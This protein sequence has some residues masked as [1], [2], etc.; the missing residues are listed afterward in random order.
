LSG[1]VSNANLSYQGVYVFGGTN[2]LQVPFTSDGGN[3]P[4]YTYHGN[5]E[6]NSVEIGEGLSVQTNVPG[7]QLFQK[8]NASVLG[9]L[10]QLATALETGTGTDVGNATN[11]VSQALSYLSQQRVFYGNSM[12]QLNSQESFLQT[13]SVN[14]KSQEN[15]LVGADLAQVTTM[16][17]QA[18]TAHDA[19]LAAAAR[20]LPTTLLDY[21]K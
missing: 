5:S 11:Q 10:Q 7:D 18:Q 9:S 8:T 20:V 15:S 16:F 12:S 4:T 21:L 19:A 6:T 3:P 14:I 17:S 1:V 2:N 13:E